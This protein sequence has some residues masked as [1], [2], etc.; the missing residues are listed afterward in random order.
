MAAFCT[1]GVSDLQLLNTEGNLDICMRK[2]NWVLDVAGIERNC[3]RYNLRDF[4]YE[5]NYSE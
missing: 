2:R 5:Y 3:S 1:L 4:D